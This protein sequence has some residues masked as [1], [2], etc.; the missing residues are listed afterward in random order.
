MNIIKKVWYRFKSIRIVGDTYQKLIGDKK[1]QRKV[2][3]EKEELEHNGINYL[4]TIEEAMNKSGG[5]YYVYAGTLLGIIR[6]KKLIKW[7]RD[8]DYA[9]VITDKFSWKDLETAMSLSGFKKVREFKLDEMVTEQTYKV[10][11]L[12]IDF[13]GQFYEGSKM[14]QYSYERI[15]D[16]T[17]D[18][19]SEYSVYRVTL[20][21]VNKT[22]RVEVENVKISVPDNAEEILSAIYNDDWRVPN[23]NWKPN[24]GHCSE[25]M[26]NKLGIQVMD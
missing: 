12:L 15:S 23:P 5:L 19:N 18:S 6:D 14:I 25:L 10:K 13:F 7:D 8:I 16:V 3:L 22:R 1:I 21:I 9:V 24:S 4:N 20:P 17:Y 26:K 2:A 11:G